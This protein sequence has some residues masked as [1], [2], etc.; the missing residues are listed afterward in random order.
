MKNIAGQVLW[1]QDIDTMH[2]P[3]IK[4]LRRAGGYATLDDCR[5][6]N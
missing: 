6:G 1:K 5:S 4:L 3:E 2:I